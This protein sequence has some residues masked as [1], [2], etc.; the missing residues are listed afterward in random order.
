MQN[1]NDIEHLLG[2]CSTCFLFP[3]DVVKFKALKYTSVWHRLFFLVNLGGAQICV[4]DIT[5]LGMSLLN[6]YWTTYK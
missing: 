4:C 5:V 3:V 6:M 2:G 1:S